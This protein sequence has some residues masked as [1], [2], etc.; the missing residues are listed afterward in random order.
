MGLAW[1]L[2]SQ[3]AVYESDHGYAVVDSGLWQVDTSGCLGCGASGVYVRL[4]R[5]HRDRI[6]LGSLPGDFIQRSREPICGMYELPSFPDR[7]VDVITVACNSSGRL[8]RECPDRAGHLSAYCHPQ[9]RFRATQ[10][11]LHL[12]AF[13][14]NQTICAVDNH[15]IPRCR[16]FCIRLYAV[17]PRGPW[18][19][20]SSTFHVRLDGN[21]RL[22]SRGGRGTVVGARFIPG[23]DKTEQY[24]V[25][26]T[27]V[28][29]PCH[30]SVGECVPGVGNALRHQVVAITHQSS[31][32]REAV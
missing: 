18:L 28:C 8:F 6:C 11:L 25:A 15:F 2:W 24:Q 21:D 30:G 5:H 14:G 1:M 20:P 4:G 19:T 3:R 32:Q 10:H 7:K 23:L 13:I 22:A 17:R 16:P 29:I 26:N 9:H 31:D 27:D 12:R